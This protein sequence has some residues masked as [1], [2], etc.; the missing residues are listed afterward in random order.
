MHR[1]C[2]RHLELLALC[3]GGHPKPYASTVDV[4]YLGTARM[5]TLEWAQERGRELV[6]SE[7]VNL[8]A[9]SAA[10]FL[11]LGVSGA[12]I[13]ASVG[14]SVGI[15]R[16]GIPV[17]ADISIDGVVGNIELVVAAKLL[18][19]SVP[20][21][22]RDTA[23]L[24]WSSIWSVPVVEAIEAVGE[25]SS[26]G[27]TALI[28][29]PA[30]PAK[31]RVVMRAKPTVPSP[32]RTEAPPSEV[33]TDLLTGS[34]G[35]SARA[36]T[37]ARAPSAELVSALQ[38]V[39]LEGHLVFLG[40][41]NVTTLGALLMHTADELEESLRRPQA[42]GKA[43]VFSPFERRML[44]TL[45][46]GGGVVATA[47]EPGVPPASL[48][49]GGHLFDYDVLGPK[50]PQPPPS[51]VSGV[52]SGCAHAAALLGAVGSELDEA[53]VAETL[54]SLAEAAQSQSSAPR[55]DSSMPQL[56][57]KLDLL[58]ESLCDK[59]TLTIEMLSP[60]MAGRRAAAKLAAK[61]TMRVEEGVR[62]RGPSVGGGGGTSFESLSRPHRRSH[63]SPLPDR[64][65]GGGGALGVADT[66]GDGRSR[67]E[68]HGCAFQPLGL[69]R[70]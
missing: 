15:E 23:R 7:F 31:S 64:G 4:S 44:Y 61:L 54:L 17:V 14:F 50:M 20:F 65:E 29:G 66:A 21:H 58:L 53:F 43:F 36:F 35:A 24:K 33:A 6:A 30:D 56:V 22:N 51:S 25:P 52:L 55:S 16:S 34:V 46:V 62:E 60:P 42:Q 38:S 11:A 9:S 63:P 69:V 5:A 32:E 27:A 47:A 49:F 41:A 57:D 68:S 59:G 10:E 8:D 40:K 45:G 26:A 2:S 18:H 37:A 1:V 28:L 48:D 39:G 3:S 70:D 67:P 13:G 19:G 12:L